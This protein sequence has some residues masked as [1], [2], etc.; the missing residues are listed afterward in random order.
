MRYVIVL[1]LAVLPLL[2]LYYVLVALQCFNI[3]RFTKCEMNG[4]L[5]MIPFYYWIK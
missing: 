1:G 4:A 2:I 5:A 3:I